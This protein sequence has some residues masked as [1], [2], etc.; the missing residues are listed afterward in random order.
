M[1]HPVASIDRRAASIS[2]TRSRPA[3]RRDFIFVAV[4]L[5]AF[6]R[7]EELAVFLFVDFFGLTSKSFDAASG[8]VIVGAGLSFARVF[9]L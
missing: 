9:S 3:E 6:S 1:R 8:S 7:T 4:S 2:S 5:G